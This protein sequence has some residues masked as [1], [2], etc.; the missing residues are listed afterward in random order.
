MPNGFGPR[1]FV[2]PLLPPGAGCLASENRKPRRSAV[3][4][5]AGGGTRTPRHADYDSAA[6]WLCGW[7]CGGWGTEKGTGMQR[8][9]LGRRTRPS[10]LSPECQI[11]PMCPYRPERLGIWTQWTIWTIWML[12]RMLPRAVS[13]LSVRRGALAAG[14]RG[15]DS[16]RMV[17]NDAR[18][19]SRAGVPGLGPATLT[20]RPGQS[21]RQRRLGRL[22][23]RGS[24][25]AGH[26]RELSFSDTPH[27]GIVYWNTIYTQLA[28]MHPRLARRGGART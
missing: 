12:P 11:R 25:S 17:C 6:L 23:A 13:L 9:S 15:C 8:L 24:G 22:L 28:S 3:S 2:A 16:E 27:Q 19:S 5:S 14:S 4:S 21:S 1:P 20:L 18:S 26:V 7:V 10:T